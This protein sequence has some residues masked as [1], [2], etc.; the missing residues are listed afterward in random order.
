MPTQNKCKYCDA[1]LPKYPVDNEFCHLDCKAA[2]ELEQMFCGED[3]CSVCNYW[4]DE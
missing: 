3:G 1:P 2:Y 4:E